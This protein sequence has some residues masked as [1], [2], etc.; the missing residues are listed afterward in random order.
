M[1]IDGSEIQRINDD[2]PFYLSAYDGWIYYF[3]ISEEDSDSNY[4]LY[5]IRT[6]GTG[7]EI[8]SEGESF[9]ILRFNVT[10]EWLYFTEV[11]RNEEIGRPAGN[12]FRIR[13]NGTSREMVYQTFES[14]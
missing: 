9:R 3:S 13:H 5:R 7:R 2:Y 4:D 1:R 14:E 6:D 10:T 11:G 12:M 8:I